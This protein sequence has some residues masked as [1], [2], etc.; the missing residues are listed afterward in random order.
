M[1]VQVDEVTVRRFLELINEHVKG[2][3]NGVGQ[4]GVLQLCR[5]NPLDDKSVVPSR[6][7]I[8]DVEHMVQTAT[9]DAAAG[10]NVYIEARTVRAGL[11]GNKRGGLEDTAWVFGLVAD[12]DADKNKGGNI[13]V[14]PSLAIE[15]SPGNFQLW[16]LF[17]R[18]IPAEQA[19]IIGDAIRAGSGTDQDTG[20]ITQC[21]RVPGTPNF[22]SLKKQ[23][24]GRLTVEPTRIFEHTGRL[25]DP[26]ELLAAFT[27]SPAPSQPQPQPAGLEAD[28]ATLPDELLEMVRHG[29]SPND[30][31][32]AL[33]HK[34]I[35]E[36][37]LR[38]WT[39][40]AVIELLEKYPKGIAEKYYPKRLR[41]EVNRSYNKFAKSVG[42]SAS[43]GAQTQPQPQQQP[44]P[45][46]AQPQPQ[47]R[48]QTV[49]P[50]IDLRAGE[51]PRIVTETENA[52]LASGLP[53]FSRAD[54]LMQPVHQIVAAAD[55]RKTMIT[56]LHELSPRSLQLALG[57]AAI[58]RKTSRQQRWVS[59]DCPLPLAQIILAKGSWNL[60]YIKGIASTPTLRPDGSLLVTPG[61]DP[62]TQ[63]YLLSDL[64]LPVIP[65]RPKLE[66]AQAALAQLSELFSEF[67]FVDQELD[68]AVALAALLTTLVR[69][70]LPIAPMVLVHAHVPGTGKSYLVDLV[71]MIATGRLCPVIA[72]VAN[73]EENDKRVGAMIL[74]GAPIISF[75]NC[76]DDLDDASILCHVTERPR[77][78]IR[79]L[80][81]SEAPECEVTSA[82]LATGNNVA[83]KGQ[84]IRRTL[85]C[86]LD[87]VT[88][89]P[90]LRRFKKNALNDA[91]VNRGTYVAA[92]LT[93]IRAYLAAGAPE[94]CGP[95]GSYSDWS[96]MVRSPLIWLGQ[97]DPFKSTEQTREEDSELA[98]IREFFDL[99]LSSDLR[100]GYDYATARIIEVACERPAGFNPPVFKQFLLRVAASKKN[101]T[102]ISP[103]RLG[104]WLR[105]ISGRVVGD[106]R[107]VMGRLNKASICFRLMKVGA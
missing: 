68:R 80:G 30:D 52:L 4:P 61:Y 62:Q 64:V 73:R 5:I 31:R 42:G 27:G 100:L 67:A 103:D 99:W 66:D 19:R 2:A 95:L 34:I 50:T 59:T 57:D 49:K 75:D 97:P 72:L 69:S 35:K 60:P 7:Q 96:R 26:D 46:P 41:A 36:L 48:S 51:L 81:R 28:E 24:R 37:W 74:G 10:H 56:R 53:I 11:R 55:G 39:V 38:H 45:Q 98:D 83:V 82:V 65:S 47:P 71:A 86:K 16:Y 77:V 21:Y 12:C 14:K 20:V 84:L 107:L 9:G 54:R 105:R 17:T 29:G 94:V 85:R 3:I 91:L 88:E 87:A 70:A 78:S 102:V 58:F 15:T 22:P 89:R 79:I 44:Q 32:S 76:N 25:W 43:S 18:A 90:E 6:F 33:F 106:F 104:W 13:T 63:F 1:S 93:I 92:A 40:E 101:D 23:A 8:G